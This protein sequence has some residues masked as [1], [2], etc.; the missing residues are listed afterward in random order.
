MGRAGHGAGSGNAHEN[1]VDANGIA[2]HDCH[3]YTDANAD[4]VANTNANA[5]TNANASCSTHFHGG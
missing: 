5:D 3:A 4:P 2:N 1:S